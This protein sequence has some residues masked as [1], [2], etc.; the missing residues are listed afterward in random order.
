MEFRNNTPREWW[1][2]SEIGPPI[3]IPKYHLEWLLSELDCVVSCN[4]IEPLQKD[5][6]HDLK[7]EK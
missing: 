5:V 4:A 3:S 1:E 7:G 2:L 6:E